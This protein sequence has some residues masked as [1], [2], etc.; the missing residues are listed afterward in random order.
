MSDYDLSLLPDQPKQY[1]FSALPDQPKNLLAGEAPPVG[2]MPDLYTSD[3]QVPSTGAR[4]L[5]ET[6]PRP[7]ERLY[8]ENAP[9]LLQDV[10]NQASPAPAAG[11]VREHPLR[12]DIRQ[13]ITWLGL[14]DREPL[15][16][17]ELNTM[18]NIPVGFARGIAGAAAFVVSNIYSSAQDQSLLPPKEGGAPVSKADVY[19]SVYKA[20]TDVLN[21]TNKEEP[22]DFASML[23]R[24]A[25][26]ALPQFA[27]LGPL[28]KAADIATEATLG[29]KFA[30][31]LPSL[32][33]KTYPMVR[34]ALTFGTYGALGPEQPWKEAGI[35]A[36]AGAVLG[37]LSP[38]GR[39]TRILGGAA[40]G[41]GQEYL[42]NPNASALDYMRSA[43]LMA[44]F[45]G[46]AAKEGL[47]L[48]EAI[49]G[50][51]RD[52]AKNKGY[53][54]EELNSAIQ[55][56][57]IWP[58]SNEFKEDMTA[59]QMENRS[60]AVGGTGPD[61][62]IG[63]IEHPNETIPGY[64]KPIPDA[65]ERFT[66]GSEPEPGIIRAGAR[67]RREGAT[68]QD[69]YGRLIA[70]TQEPLVGE[71]QGEYGKLTETPE[72]KNWFGDSKVVFKEGDSDYFQNRE[73]T[74]GIPRMVYH[75]TGPKNNF[76]IFRPD[77][78]GA[79]WFGSD[80][81]AAG[82]YAGRGS[83]V[84]PAFLKME[85]PFEIQSTDAITMGDAID[86]AKA[87]GN[88]GV[89][90]DRG[91]GDY[92]YAVFSPDQVKSPVVG[93]A[94]STPEVDILHKSAR[95][96]TSDAEES[97]VV[98]KEDQRPGWQRGQSAFATAETECTIAKA[99]EGIEKKPVQII[100][101]PVRSSVDLAVLAQAWRNPHYEEL[102]YVFIKRGVIVD[103]EGV[104]C[105]HPGYSLSHWG[106][107]A[108][109]IAHLRERIEALGATALYM[110]HNHPV[111]NPK[112][113]RADIQAT[114]DIARLIPQLAGH[115]IINSGK[116][117]Y[118]DAISKEDGVYPLP[119]LPKDWVD[120]ILQPSI[121][122]ELL[123]READTI[124]HIA[125]WAKAL[126][127][128]R[129]VPV[130]VYIDSDLKVRGLQEIHPQSFTDIQL[131]RDRM[132]QKLVDFGSIGAVAVLPENATDKM[133]DAVRYYVPAHVLW[134]AVKFD[135]NYPSF[136]GG[137]EPKLEYFGGRLSKALPAQRIR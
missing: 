67:E 112:P 117:A 72:F 127:R 128:D 68:P 79:I 83:A 133:L 11:P 25:S 82:D 71:R 94:F 85:N 107:A 27:L 103:H 9:Q 108:Q 44:G 56:K 110:V 29:G 104:T 73:G 49:K 50:T 6:G 115:I 48:D 52:W 111:G 131:M 37:T 105:M 53:T 36:G 43:T 101:L 92:T 76:E 135:G 120:P 39:L 100:N 7:P 116:Y 42:A 41:A 18:E 130:L 8:R 14:R 90:L 58:V 61:E 97:K 21:I 77:E 62:Q 121:P 47:T 118:I 70:G 12:P 22:H 32:Y 123:G 55:A 1:D 59:P 51:I 78:G 16:P 35:G 96:D 91:H 95:S 88:D 10:W 113:S 84:I 54:P 38:Y 64:V 99:F 2:M 129:D 28:G 87:Q 75:G 3:E 19:K 66:A 31:A 114:N 132:P 81:R 4:P 86:K 40:V 109:F 17:N 137:E 33:A 15:L 60:G 20:I 124:Q 45:A 134:H 13:E 30:E 74:P 26:E 69:Q 57:G 63:T 126:T 65:A 80:Q 119:N 136:Y 125:G 98:G 24:G 122:H 34:D 89:I 106:D 5:F 23:L 46:L 93:T 102:R